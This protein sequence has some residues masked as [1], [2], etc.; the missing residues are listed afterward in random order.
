MS[1]L[2]HFLGIEIAHSKEDIY[3]S[4]CKY[5]VD[6]LKEAGILIAKSVDTLIKEKKAKNLS[7]KI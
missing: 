2:K 3:I 5:I 6:I 7:R 1:D 4:K